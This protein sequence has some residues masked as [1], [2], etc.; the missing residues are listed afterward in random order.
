MLPTVKEIIFSRTKLPYYI[1]SMYVQFK[2][3]LK[4]YMYQ[5]SLFLQSKFSSTDILFM[6]VIIIFFLNLF[7][8]LSG[9]F[10]GNTFSRTFPGHFLIL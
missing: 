9:F 5:Y 1:Y 10:T 4:W 2:F 7:F 6:R 8:V 3:E